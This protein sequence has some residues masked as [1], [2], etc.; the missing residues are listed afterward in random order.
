MKAIAQLGTPLASYEGTAKVTGPEPMKIVEVNGYFELSHLSS[1]RISVGFVP[2]GRGDP[3]PTD[4]PINIEAQTSLDY[5]LAFEGQDLDGWILK[6]TGQMLFSRF[7]WL[8]LPMT[9]PPN[10]LYFSPLYLEAR[11]NG[12]SETGYTKANFLLSN[13]LWDD[14]SSGEPEPVQ[15]TVQ[16]FTVRVSPVPD[17]LPIAERLTSMHGVEPTACVSIESS[18]GECQPLD[19]YRK[20]LDNLLYVFRLVTGNQIN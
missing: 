9:R 15:L 18:L 14:Y 5:E 8:F 13:L 7:S 4:T 3:R 19:V 6:N 20:F 17:Y 11:R 1:G 16:G 10:T 12:A 2:N